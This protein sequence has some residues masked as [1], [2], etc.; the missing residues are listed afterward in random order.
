MKTATGEASVGPFLTEERVAIQA[1]AR[2]FVSREVLPVANELDPVGGEIPLEL[3]AKMADLGFFGI[4][5]P[6]EYGGLGLGLS[7]YAIVVEELARGWMSVASL[8]ARGQQFTAGFTAEQRERFLPRM[9]R[10]EFLSAF[11]LSEPEAGSDVAN[12]ATRARPDGDGWRITG[13]KM[14][15]TFA[16][17]ADYLQVFARTE[18]LDPAHRARG[19]TCFLMPKERG[20]LPEGVKGTPVRKIGYHGWKTWELSFED[21]WADEIVGE[22][23]RGFAIAMGDLD[24]ARIHTAA[25]AIGLAR[26]GLE[27]AIRYAAERV[28]FG[29][30]IGENQAI[31]FKIAEMA[32]EIAAARALMNQV[33]AAVD[34]GRASPLTASM[35]KLFA[36]DMAERVTSEA[37]QIHGGAGYTTDYPVERYWR[38]ARLT[39][40]FEGTSEIQKRIISDALLGRGGR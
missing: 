12:L 37:L 26:G 36:S 7:E 9:A 5:I 25:R 3:R 19:I 10:G 27:D 24:T 38:D 40:I 11:A 1:M 34:T 18:P 30:P 2:D 4:L 29:K 28:Q 8:V 21:A 39:R 35:V 31:R 22:R 32:T 20:T 23:G 14:W 16:D 15:C 33:C 6:E 17:G 13:Q